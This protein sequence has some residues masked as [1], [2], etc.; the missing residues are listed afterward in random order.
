MILELPLIEQRASKDFHVSIINGVAGSGKTL[1]LLYRLRMLH[2]RFPNH[3]FLILTHNRPL[4][5]DIQARYELLTGDLPKNISW[6]A[7]NA[8]CR[9]YWPEQEYPWIDPI[10]Q[11]E[12]E[13]IAQHILEKYFSGMSIHLESFMGEIDWF[14]DQIPMD[15]S[16]C[17][18]AEKGRGF[19]LN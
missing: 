11:T 4:I 15:K 1:I 18:E 8:F 16:K 19:R 7:F 13:R 6:K 17:L 3:N 12:R 2:S 5:R 14:K 10:G 9:R